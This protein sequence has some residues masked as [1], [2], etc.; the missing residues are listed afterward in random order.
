MLSNSNHT[1][2]ADIFQSTLTIESRLS[3]GITLLA[4]RA[5]HF[6]RKAR[7]AGEFSSNSH[8]SRASVEIFVPRI[9]SQERGRKKKD[10]KAKLQNQQHQRS[11]F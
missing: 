2:D 1:I 9:S 5:L 11:Q 4:I 6:L 10:A 3:Q 8:Q 7:A